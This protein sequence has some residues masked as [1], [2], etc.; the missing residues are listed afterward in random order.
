MAKELGAAYTVNARKEDP[1]AAIKASAARTRPSRW[2]SRPRRSS[3]RMARS[4]G[5]T[6]VFVG[7]PA[8]NH[9]QLPIFETV[10]NG[11]T[12]V[13]SIVGTRK[14]L[15]EVYELHARGRTHVI[16]ETRS[17][18]TVNQ[19]IQ[20]VLGGT[21]NARIVFD[22]R[23]GAVTEPLLERELAAAGVSAPGAK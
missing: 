11:I 3:R 10:L 12:I 5:G 13:G 22:L 9:I 16:R 20:D 23:N 19:S 8:D 7:L 15:D 6:L 2:P 1:A 14:D 21:V 18:D 4:A 17:L